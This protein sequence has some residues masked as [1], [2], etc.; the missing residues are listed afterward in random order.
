MPKLHGRFVWHELMTT[1]PAAARDFYA[2]VAGWGTRDA[3]MPELPYTL[4]TLGET[5]VGGLMELPEQARNQ[6]ARAGW[7]GYVAVDDV[8]AAVAEVQRLGGGVHVPPWDLPVGRMAVVA[9]PQRAVLVLFKGAEDWPDLPPGT[10]GR[11]GWN[12]LLAVEWD[13]AFEFYATMFGWRKADAVDMGP[14]GT[15]QLF[16]LDGPPFGGMFNKP[17]AIPEPFW[18]YYITVGDIDAAI[19]R[20]TAG[21]GQVLNGPVEVSG[22][23]IAQAMDPQGALFALLGRREQS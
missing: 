21:G 22:G 19:G 7:V 12:E 16:G 23:W 17:A 13:K 1:D 3:S 5:P 9:D 4:F 6:G 10:P 2:A 20:V 14:L 15:Y 18:L 11:F 8:D